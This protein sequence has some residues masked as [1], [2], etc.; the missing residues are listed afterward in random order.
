MAKI[1]LLVLFVFTCSTCSDAIWN[2]YKN[3]IRGSASPRRSGESG[4]PLFL[5]PL[6]Q[7]G[8]IAEARNRARVDLP[9]MSAVESYSGF[10]TV[11]SK[12]NSNLFFWYVP[13]QNNREN[14]PLLVWLQGG[15]GAS[16]LF[17]MFEENGPFFVQTNNT[18]KQREYS[19]HQNHHMIYVDNPVGTGFSFTDSEEGYATNEEQVGENL[20]KFIHQ[21]FVMFPN[22]LT[23][24]F[25]IAGESYGGK[26]VPAFAY[27]MH[28]SQDQ[29]K[30]NL[31]GLAIGDGY[32]DP[33]NQLNYGEYLYELGLVDMNGRQKFDQD[34]AAAIECAK[35]KDMQCANRL[36]GGL[37]DGVD[38]QDSFFKRVTGFSSYYNYVQ[39]DECNSQNSA[40]VE[41]L[42]NPEVRKAIHVGERPFNDSDGDNK[43]AEKL[44]DDTLETVAPWVGK[45]LSH[46]RVLFYNGQLDVI[47]AYPMTV[48]FLMKMPFDGD[49][50]YKRAVRE[51]YRV[52][53]EVAGY[54][55]KAGRLQEVMIRN[56]GH[57]VPR[58]Q[59][60]WAFDMISSFT[61]KGSL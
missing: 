13:A 54:K 56:A 44:S 19:W 6:L 1:H 41:F 55:K 17:G 29:P 40:L 8:K 14:A 45:L 16:S 32:T 47:C 20:M 59:P 15:P 33:L 28:T 31:Q 5:T 36:I 7:D 48:N 57:M 11:D 34:T 25:Y 24:P 52:D 39:G 51:I 53:G 10:M 61:H 58:D 42:S 35:R 4:E 22:L 2:P 27:A 18:L 60:K 12:F 46:Y 26:Y 38:G 50:E 37:F 23:H 3:L 9:M 49:N 43:V 30:I 21:F